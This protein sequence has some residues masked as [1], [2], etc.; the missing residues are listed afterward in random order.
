MCEPQ[1]EAL[2]QS[3]LLAAEEAEGMEKTDKMPFCFKL[4]K[5]NHQ[6]TNR[7]KCSLFQ[8]VWVK[9][10]YVLCFIYFFHI[11]Y[12]DDMKKVFSGAY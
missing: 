12:Y 6:G 3:R 2:D 7:K 10:F 11:A 9:C 8:K 5:K 4:I 1:A